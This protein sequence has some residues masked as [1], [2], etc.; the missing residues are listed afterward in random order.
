MKL[1]EWSLGVAVAGLA[2]A[3]VAGTGQLDPREVEK[4]TTPSTAQVCLGEAQR[5]SGKEHLSAGEVVALYDAEI[6]IGRFASNFLNMLSMGED[7]A[8]FERSERSQ[9][10]STQRT[11]ADYVQAHPERFRRIY[12]GYKGEGDLWEPNAH[13]LGVLRTRYPGSEERWEIEWDLAWKDLTRQFS[14]STQARGKSCAQ[15]YEEVMAQDRE[16]YRASYSE[17]EIAKTI[18]DC[19]R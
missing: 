12:A 19:E 14:F 7:V 13:W 9:R 15:Y 6:C 10:M 4:L 1:G 3:S 2:V 16:A 17:K 18:A 5:L 11:T 8:E